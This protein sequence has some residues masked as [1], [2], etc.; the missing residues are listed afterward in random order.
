MQKTCP[1]HCSTRSAKEE[2]TH[3]GKKAKLQSSAH[4]AA[5]L[6]PCTCPWYRCSACY[7]HCTGNSGVTANPETLP[8]HKCPCRRGS[9][10]RLGGE[11]VHLSGVYLAEDTA[12]GF[13]RYLSL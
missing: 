6:G 9:M 13:W 5:L 10:A 12:M 3:A 2:G 7:K 1:S 11:P 8:G 4:H